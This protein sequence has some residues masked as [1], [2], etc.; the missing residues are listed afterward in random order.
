MFAINTLK[1]FEE[2]IDK[3]TNKN[4]GCTLCDPDRI[5]REWKQAVEEILDKHI[6][7]I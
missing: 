1:M 4:C 6:K 2:F 3:I 5:N 7:A